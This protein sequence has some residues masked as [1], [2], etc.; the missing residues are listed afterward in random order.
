[1]YDKDL[2]EMR[3]KFELTMWL[4][5]MCGETEKGSGGKNV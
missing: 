3:P 5:F 1:M 2:R 4:Q